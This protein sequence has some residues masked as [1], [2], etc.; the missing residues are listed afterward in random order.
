MTSSG[1]AKGYLNLRKQI[2]IQIIYTP[3]YWY[4]VSGYYEYNYKPLSNNLNE[5]LKKHLAVFSFRSFVIIFSSK[6]SG[7]CTL[8]DF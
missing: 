1:K 4:R 2:N 7:E 5:H 6:H 8:G 3:A